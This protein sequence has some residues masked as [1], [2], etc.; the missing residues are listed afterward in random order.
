MKNLFF[1]ATAIFMISCSTNSW[2]SESAYQGS[3]Q[4]HEIRYG[5]NKDSVVYVQTSNGSNSSNFFINYLLFRTLFSSGGYSNVYNYYQTHPTEF[6]RSS[7]STYSSYKPKVETRSYVKPKSSSSY[8]SP[9]RK[10]KYN[11]STPSSS[12]SRS[13][14]SP[15]RSYSSPSRSYSSPSRSY[16]SPSRSYSSPSR[17]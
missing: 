16:S 8:T 3:S 11:Y 14:S 1:L 2:D 12:S 9:S 17:R 10:T 6:T 15:S 7:Q 4:G 13:Y 5:P